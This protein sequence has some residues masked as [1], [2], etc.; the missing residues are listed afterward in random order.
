MRLLTGRVK[1]WKYGRSEHALIQQIFVLI[2]QYSLLDMKY[3]FFVCEDCLTPC[4]RSS[5]TY[6]LQFL[7]LSM[8]FIICHFYKYARRYFDYV[9]KAF[10]YLFKRNVLFFSLDNWKKQEIFT[11]VTSTIFLYSKNICF[12][13]FCY[14]FSTSQ[15]CLK[16]GQLMKFKNI[17]LS[18]DYL[19]LRIRIN[20]IIVRNFPHIFPR[21][22]VF[23]NEGASLIF[24][25]GASVPVGDPITH[26]VVFCFPPSI[27]RFWL[28]WKFDLVFTSEG[29]NPPGYF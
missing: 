21:I 22:V 8:I 23:M 15:V 19:F 20:F 5:W 14:S 11:S 12:L 25:C 10:I 18:L 29:F 1:L 6:Y 7:K 17:V 26:S 9:F 3:C 4:L 2:W 27:E 24:N 13:F 16:L 28:T